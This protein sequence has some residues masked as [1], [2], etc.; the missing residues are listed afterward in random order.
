MTE[1]ELLDW[2][3]SQSSENGFIEF[4]KELLNSMARQQAE[5]IKDELAHNTLMKLPAGEVEFFEWL[6]E[7]DHAVWHDLWGG[8]DLDHPPY[9]IGLTFLPEMV[10]SSGGLFPIC[11]LLSTDN[12]YFTIGHMVDKESEILID[13]V[14]DRFSN[15]EKLTVAQLLV[16]EISLGPVDIWHF[17]FK[18]KLSVEKAKSAAQELVEDDVLVHLKDAEHL[19]GFLEF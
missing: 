16:L 12:Y 7:A 19:A 6:K 9:I 8:N 14:R 5:L 13:S 1:V 17:A 15:K 3:R 4:D 11:D 18:Y 10:D 2:C